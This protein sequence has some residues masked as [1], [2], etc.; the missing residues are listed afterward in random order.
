MCNSSCG[1]WPLLCTCART[2]IQVP[3][4]C[5]RWILQAPLNLSWSFVVLVLSLALA[6]SRQHPY[7]FL[8]SGW[9]YSKTE[10]ARRLAPY[11]TRKSSSPPL[12]IVI[13]SGISKMFFP[14]L[15]QPILNPNKNN[16]NNKLT[17][18]NNIITII[19]E[20]KK[21]RTFL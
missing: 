13:H 12:G 14:I 15:S 1:S 7:H 20:D 5:I 11:V 10:K 9:R 8:L 3:E 21:L 19:K 18:N 16:K 6:I 2:E 17:N 4:L